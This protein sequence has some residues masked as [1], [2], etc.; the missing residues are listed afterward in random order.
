MIMHRIFAAASFA[1]LALAAP[2]MAQTRPQTFRGTLQACPNGQ[3][4]RLEAGQ[5]Y[6]I[7]A[8]STAFDPVLRVL[9]RGSSTVLVQD[10]DG[11]EGNNSRL[12]FAP[13]RSGRY[14]LCVSSFGAGGTGA[15]TITVERAGRASCCRPTPPLTP[16]TRAGRW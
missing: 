11:G 14:L 10:D 8:A 15:Y 4:I 2:A 13:A 7:S 6:T 9:A 3:D 12:T 5:R 1:A 16:A